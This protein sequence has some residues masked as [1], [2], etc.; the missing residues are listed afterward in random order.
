MK[1]LIENKKARLE[2]EILDTYEAGLSLYGFEVKGLRAG[3]ASLVGSRVVVRGGEAY[4]VGAS[5]PPYQ[6]KNTPKD[7]DPERSRRLLLNAKEIAE[8]A[9]QEG[10]KRLTIIP[11]MVYNKGRRLKLQI[12]IARHKNKRDKRE[13]LKGREA[14]RHIERTLKNEE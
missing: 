5:I 12:G 8:L 13:T 4:L 7:Y 2:H 14:K 11:L 10:Q 3:N 1:A 9:A 6:E